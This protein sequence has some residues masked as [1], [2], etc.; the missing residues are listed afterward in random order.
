[1]SRGSVLF[2]CVSARKGVPKAAVDRVEL[3]PGVGIVGDAH[4]GAWHR[5]VSMLDEADIE[6]MRAQGLDLR[7]GAFGENLVLSGLDLARLGIGSV[8]S[9]GTAEL[10]VTQ[11]GKVCHARCAI[12]VASG[13]CIMPRLGVFAE[14]K[15][16]GEVAPGMEVRVASEVPRSLPQ[17]AVLTVSDRCA[18]GEMADTAGPAVAAEVARALDAHLAWSGIV[19][20]ERETIADRLRD[21]AGRGIDLVLTVGGTGLGPRDVTPEATR[22]V[23]EREVPGLPEAMRAASAA[24]TPNA[25][26]S[27]AVAGLRAGTLIVNLPGSLAGATENLHAVLE[28]LEHAIKMIRGTAGHPGA[29]LGRD[30]PRH[31]Q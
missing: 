25:W 5:Q 12:Y 11:I 15:A 24:L 17:A 8:L 26:L 21:L 13:D 23:V 3:R 10:A 18:A 9:V 20:D 29:D 2:V 6:S 14:V 22:A 30:L 28:P 27:R 4:A 1:M 19:P 7:P 16:P 31:T